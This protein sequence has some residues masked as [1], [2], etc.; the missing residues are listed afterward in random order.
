MEGLIVIE[1]YVRNDGKKKKQRKNKAK[2][3]SLRCF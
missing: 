1:R 3:K 2:R